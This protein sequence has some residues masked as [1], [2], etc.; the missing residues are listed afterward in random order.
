MRSAGA[1]RGPCCNDG[2]ARWMCD[3]TI[4]FREKYR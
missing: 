1:E 2:I 3:R 4:A